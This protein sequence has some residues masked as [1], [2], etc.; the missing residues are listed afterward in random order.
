MVW[1]PG[2]SRPA[3]PG[4]STALPWLAAV[5][6]IGLQ[7]CYPL[8]SGDQRAAVTV[9]SVL[10]F[11]TA[12][13]GAAAA[14]HG[15]G[16]AAAAA[17]VASATGL[18]A[19]SVGVHTGWPFGDYAYGG[20]LGPKLVGVPVVVPLAWTMMG[21]PALALGLRCAARLRARAGAGTRW[22]VTALVGGATLT[23]WDFFLDPQM[24]AEGYWSW[25]SGGP[26][27]NGIPVSNAAGWMLVGTVLTGALAALPDR[28]TAGRSTAAPTATGP[29]ATSHTGGDR[30]PMTL[31]GWTYLSSVLAN[32]AF[33]GRPGVALVGGVAMGALLGLG[34]LPGRRGAAHHGNLARSEA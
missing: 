5:A 14:A 20:A 25:S 11:C 24:V 17:S 33:F 29:T 1:R 18:I 32:L 23:A 6:T 8:T 16:R 13:V 28:A 21:L 34:V 2:V 3:W 10:A 4:G 7:I 27:I 22:A 12:S 15:L 30:L 19:E 26:A 31:L 9:L